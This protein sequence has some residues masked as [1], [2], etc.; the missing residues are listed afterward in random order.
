MLPF[1]SQV[2]WVSQLNVSLPLLSSKEINRLVILTSP[3]IWGV[4]KIDRKL[5]RIK[6]NKWLKVNP[7][8]VRENT[9]ILFC[10]QMCI[11]FL[12]TIILAPSNRPLKHLLMTHFVFCLLFFTIRWQL[13][14]NLEF[15]LYIDRTKKMKSRENKNK[16]IDARVWMI[17]VFH[18]AKLIY[19]LVRQSSS[20]K[21][22][23]QKYWFLIGRFCLSY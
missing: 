9:S 16:R 8:L 19:Y 6:A 13:K 15:G 14:Q 21:G 23:C 3:L 20:G 5:S 17:R 10:L 22:L 18:L 11:L 2:T 7:F 4:R 12:A 1:H